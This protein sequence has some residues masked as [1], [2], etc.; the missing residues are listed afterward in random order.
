MVVQIVSIN[1]H[2]NFLKIVLLENKIF[3]FLEE[4]EYRHLLTTFI[5]YFYFLFYWIMK[6]SPVEIPR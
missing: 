5:S 1:F 3:V 6:Y 4:D 2:P